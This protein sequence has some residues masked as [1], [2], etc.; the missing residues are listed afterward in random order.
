M[1]RFLLILLAA[2][3]CLVGTALPARAATTVPLEHFLVS[4]PVRLSATHTGAAQGK[5]LTSGIQLRGASYNSCH[6]DQAIFHLVKQNTT[7]NAVVYI[8]DS[9][10][11]SSASVEFYKATNFT[12]PK[13]FTRLA[14]AKS[15]KRPH[16][17]H[18]KRSVK[19]VKWLIVE[20]ASKTCCVSVDVVGQVGTGT[21]KP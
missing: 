19:G 7:L 10:H 16:A 9:S 4:N 6:C 1:P 12:N 8:D 21:A 5:K 18:V 11:Q 3:A 2:V 14:A 15:V 13:T 17:W 20:A